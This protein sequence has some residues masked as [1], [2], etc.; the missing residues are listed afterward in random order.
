MVVDSPNRL[1]TAPLIWSHP[2]H[3]IELTPDEVSHIAGLA[4]FDVTKLRG[5]WI[6]RDRDRGTI[7]PLDPNAQAEGW[8]TIERCLAAAN[9]PENS[10][11]WWMEA[12]RSERAPRVEE[13]RNEVDRIYAKAWPERSRRFLTIIGTRSADGATF[14]STEAGALIYGPYMPLRA[15]NHSVDF[16]IETMSNTSDVCVR[17]DVCGG[18]KEIVSRDLSASELKA[19]NGRVTLRFHLPELQFGIEAR[20][21]SYGNSELTAGLPDI[22]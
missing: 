11:L 8:T 4:G 21:I 19:N 7:L 10:L 18:G 13:L 22:G 16:N 3:T 5:I 1:V 17:V 6:C 9:D 14:S 12:A 15:G 2:E 20:V